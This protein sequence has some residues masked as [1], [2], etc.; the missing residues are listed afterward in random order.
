MAFYIKPFLPEAA[1]RY[2]NH[3]DIR[4]YAGQATIRV[5]PSQ[6]GPMRSLEAN[7]LPMD[8]S[9]DVEVPLTDGRSARLFILCGTKSHNGMRGK[10]SAHRTFAICPDCYAEV[11][12]GRTHQHKCKG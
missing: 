9:A 1:G 3:A 2:A 5:Y 7:K 12:A 10:S 8:F 6:V 11:P 4:A